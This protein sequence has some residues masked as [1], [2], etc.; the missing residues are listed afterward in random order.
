MKRQASTVSAAMPA[1]AAITV[2]AP[3]PA[4]STVPP[5]TAVDAQIVRSRLPER[6]RGPNFGDEPEPAL[7]LA[8]AHAAQQREPHAQLRAVRHRHVA[9]SPEPLLERQQGSG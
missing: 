9:E 7:R 2:A 6:P 3:K 8:H 4:A 1:K 5:T